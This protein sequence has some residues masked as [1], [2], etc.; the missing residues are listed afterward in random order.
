MKST[1]GLLGIGLLVT[2]NLLAQVE[3]DDMY[4]NKQDR[5]K[6]QHEKSSYERS[7]SS[8][9]DA[10]ARADK[11][12]RFNYSVDD[13]TPISDRD[14]N[15][16][17]VSR[18]QSEMSASEDESYFDENYRFNSQSQLNNFN[19]NLNNWNNTP[20]YSNNFFAPNIYGWNSP[21]YSPFND[22][23]LNGFNAN[24]WCNPYFNSGWSAAFSFGWGN[25][26]GYGWNRPGW[27]M[28][29]NYGW[30]DPFWNWGA[31][32]GPSW[33]WGGSFWN[34]YG[35]NAPVVIVDGNARGAVYGKRGSRNQ[36]IASGNNTSTIAGSRSTNARTRT[37][38]PVLNDNS[39]T[40]RSSQGA[41]SASKEYYTPQWRRPVQS[42]DFD[43]NNTQNRLNNRSTTDFFNNRSSGSN[44][45]S[46]ST[47]SRSSSP[48]FSSPS[49]S[50][51]PSGG[52]SGGSRSRGRGN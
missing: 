21:F 19:N 38:S 39:N 15:P 26:W 43:N 32:W 3:H 17:Y 35:W 29:L 27:N 6:L 13:A 20:L 34:N 16:E 1:I 24:P 50:S 14:L 9:E 11:P 49:R 51:S 2:T 37:T 18:S 44:N 40:T 28:G 52:S 42:S 30:G 22:P 41:R 46:F 7:Y 12:V 47:P 4:F 23:F 10:L 25:S 36:I 31:T 48:S 33:G 8:T 5:A 45:N